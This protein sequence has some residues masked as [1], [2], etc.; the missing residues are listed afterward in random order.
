MCDLWYAVIQHTSNF[1]MS[2]ALSIRIPPDIEQRLD[3]EVARLHTTKSKY[4]QD[5]L[6]L[7]LEPKDPVALLHQIRAD[8]G[9]APTPNSASTDRSSNTKALVKES[10]AR[11]LGRATSAPGQ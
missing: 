2:N 8:L 7:A 5:L 3:R 4:V 11:K 10:I 9:I 6:K 1:T